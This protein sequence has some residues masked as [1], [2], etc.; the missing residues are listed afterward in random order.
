MAHVLDIGAEPQRQ[1]PAEP[2]HLYAVDDLFL[3]R[4][5]EGAGDVSHGMASRSEVGRVVPGCYVPS[6]YRRVTRITSYLEKNAHVTR[7]EA[8]GTSTDCNECAEAV[9]TLPWGVT[10]IEALRPQRQRDAGACA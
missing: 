10:Q 7:R 6:G 1:D 3:W 2:Y 5:R 8:I 9:A 4:T